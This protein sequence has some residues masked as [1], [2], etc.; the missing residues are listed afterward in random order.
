MLLF[1]VLAT[2]R[3]I[4]LMCPK[5]ATADDVLCILRT[6]KKKFLPPGISEHDVTLRIENPCGAGLLP[7]NFSFKASKS[8]ATYRIVAS[9]GF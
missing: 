2:G 5:D 1:H 9:L 7:D 6:S 3:T 8:Y 4:S